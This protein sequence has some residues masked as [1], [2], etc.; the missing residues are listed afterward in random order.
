[1]KTVFVLLLLL[2]ANF[3]H[4]Q[5]LFQDH[6][7]AADL[8]M[9][10]RDKI[11]LTD[12]QATAIKEIHSKNAGEFSVLKWDLEAAT[13]GLKEL[14]DNTKVDM[15]AIEKQMDKV[16]SLENQLKKLQLG[17]LVAIKNELTEQQQQQLDK[18]KPGGAVN[19][20][21]YGNNNFTNK[22]QSIRIVDSNGGNDNPLYLVIDD[23]KEKMVENLTAIQPDDIESVSVLKGPSA[24][25]KYG[26]KG[27]NGVVVITLKQ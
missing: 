19:V 18:T 6:L 14:M 15:H 23:G 3:T 4:A 5:D 22:N 7:Y 26:A 11:N 16:L 12:Q 17:T 2:L 25:K 9:S 1:M 8:V 10:Q 21:G 27:K 20:I 24:V 13:S